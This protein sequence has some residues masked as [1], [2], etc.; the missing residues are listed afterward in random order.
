VAIKILTPGLEVI[1]YTYYMCRGPN[2]EKD[3]ERLVKIRV[4]ENT[5]FNCRPNLG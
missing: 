5:D 2:R 3:K 1:V 4:L